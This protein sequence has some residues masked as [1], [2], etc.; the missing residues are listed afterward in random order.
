MNRLC[1]FTNRLI[2]IFSNRKQL[3]PRSLPSPRSPTEEKPPSQ[4]WVTNNDWSWLDSSPCSNK[5]RVSDTSS[6]GTSLSPTCS[7]SRMLINGTALLL[8]RSLLRSKQRLS[9]D[10]HL[11]RLVCAVKSPNFW[12]EAFPQALS[13][14]GSDFKMLKGGANQDQDLSPHWV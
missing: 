4:A 8:R 2:H 5:N 3:S 6:R 12:R 7:R 13:T 14:W 9:L 1:N 11:Y 10:R